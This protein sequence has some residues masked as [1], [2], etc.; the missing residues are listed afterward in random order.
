MKKTLSQLAEQTATT[1][2]IGRTLAKALGKALAEGVLKNRKIEDLEAE[3]ERP[4]K[5]KKVMEDPN[6][7]FMRVSEIAAQARGVAP[8]VV[9]EGEEEVRVEAPRRSGR[10]T[11]AT[12]RKREAEDMIYDESD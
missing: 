10:V 1:R 4:K 12:A 7:R 9:I 5:R 2:A 11:R 3:N 8:V 6:S